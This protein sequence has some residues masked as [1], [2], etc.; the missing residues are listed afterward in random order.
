MTESQ[1]EQTRRD[2]PMISAED[3]RFLMGVLL[4]IRIASS[5]YGQNFWRWIR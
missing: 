3:E 4:G 1:R 2:A 5:V